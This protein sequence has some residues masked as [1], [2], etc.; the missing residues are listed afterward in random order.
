[1]HDWLLIDG[2]HLA[3]RSFYGVA[4]LST[5]D[6]F[7]TNAIH[8]WMATLL[9]IK[10]QFPH[11]NGLIAFDLVRS[12]KR[13]SLLET[14]K[15][16]RT[17]QPDTLKQQFPIIKEL[18]LAFGYAICESVD[19]E[20][21]DLLASAAILVEKRQETAL[22][23]SA[24]KDFTQC[25]NTH[26]SLLSPTPIG[27]IVLNS[28]AIYQKYGLY[29]HQMVDFLALIGDSVDCIPGIPGVGPKTATQW[30]QKFESIANIFN[31][32]DSIK[33][34]RFRTILSQSSDLLKRNQ[35]L[36]QLD[37]TSLSELPVAPPQNLPKM[38]EI[39]SKLHLNAIRKKLEP[40]QACP[41][42]QMTLF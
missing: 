27:W 42:A 8:G 35:T 10:E 14:Y 31:H 19:A 16:T 2:S 3:F 38:D 9:R 28:Q 13:L 24:D 40:Q 41:A 23:A 30:L 21:D 7:P 33:P 36:I 29:P 39:L 32:L 12:K 34:E 22:I 4:E 17:P 25:V 18:S 11:K 20:A 15:S 1:M 6:G 37:Q 26:I 5:P